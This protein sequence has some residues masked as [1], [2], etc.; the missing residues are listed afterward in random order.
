MR[1]WGGRGV[2]PDHSTG[3]L[4]KRRVAERLPQGPIQP[5]V[6]APLRS[7]SGKN[8]PKEREGRPPQAWPGPDATTRWHSFA[9]FVGF[10]S[11]ICNLG[12]WTPGVFSRLR[13]VRGTCVSM[14][15]CAYVGVCL[16]ICTNVVYALVCLC[17]SVQLCVY[18]YMC[19]HVCS[20]LCVHVRLCLR[21][22]VGRC[23][24]V[25]IL[26]FVD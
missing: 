3:P 17:L 23:T 26:M 22:Y 9:G 25:H 10:V 13:E 7:G 21:A 12:A 1:P 5:V 18:T 15:A 14:W 24:C 4:L 2:A 19:L 8:R 16:S 11:F 20:C 6:S